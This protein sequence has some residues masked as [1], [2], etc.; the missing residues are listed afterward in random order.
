MI[1]QIFD[2]AQSFDFFTK[3]KMINRVI[4]KHILLNNTAGYVRDI[5]FQISV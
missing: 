5:Y 1:Y 2:D 3:L 4:Q